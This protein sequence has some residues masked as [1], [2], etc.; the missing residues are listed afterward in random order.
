M[1]TRGRCFNQR[2]LHSLR[3]RCSKETRLAAVD[4][5]LM[6]SPDFVLLK[7]KDDRACRNKKMSSSGSKMS[8][9]DAALELHKVEGS[10]ALLLSRKGTQAADLR[11]DSA[12]VVGGGRDRHPF[13]P[14]T[15]PYNAGLLSAPK[16]RQLD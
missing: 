4:Q 2:L 16:M 11:L 1:P 7:L 10:L 12:L 14:Q 3:P 13:P 15:T 6:G 9:G 5:V 8:D